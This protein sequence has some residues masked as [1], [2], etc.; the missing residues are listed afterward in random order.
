[1]SGSAGTHL[2]IVAELGP[3]P[4]PQDHA[5]IEA[6]VRSVRWSPNPE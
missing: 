5:L 2:L 3:D 4:S 1:M 6:I